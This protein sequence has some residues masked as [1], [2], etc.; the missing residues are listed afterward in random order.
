MK[1]APTT[2]M[3]LAA[4]GALLGCPS[5]ESIRGIEHPG[6]ERPAASHDGKKN[7]TCRGGSIDAWAP[8]GFCV[9]TFAGDLVRPRHMVFAP[10]G[11][12][13]VATRTGIVVLWDADGDGKS[14]AR[15]RATLGGPDLSQQGVALSPD[16][17]WLYLADSRAVRR[18][19]FRPGLRQNEGAGEVVIPDVPLTVDHPYRTITFDVSGRLY[20]SVG[21]DDNL[22]PGAGAAI[23]RYAIPDVLPPRGIAYASGER[24]A[25]GLRNG[26]ALAWAHDGRLWA[27]VNGRDFLRPPGTADTFYL[28]HP[29]DW[30]YRLSDRAGTFYGFPTCWVLG[31]VPWGERRDPASQ[32]ADPDA[33]QGHD[34]AWCQN[35]ANV[36]PAAGALPAHTAPLGAVEYTGTLFPPK[37]KNT[38]FV[39]SHGSW[40]RHGK[41]RG[42]SI[43]G[44]RVEGERVVDIETFVGERSANKNLEEGTWSERP[45]GIAQGPDGALYFASDETGRV[46]RVG[47]ARE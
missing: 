20:L 9:T 17:R 41:Q 36:Q 37:Y 25:A 43:L 28:D 33:N 46:M 18:V 8:P 10:N 39:T 34:D 14:D 29:G 30:I 3:V 12:L 40:N 13:L 38:F 35:P 7:P 24:F 2:L 45:V 42:R 27:F 16:G 44:V 1:A 4:L 31:S 47:Y 26:E 15:E 19:P 5:G 32:W 23:M 6:T 21:A 22:T 11:D